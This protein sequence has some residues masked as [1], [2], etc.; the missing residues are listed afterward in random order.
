MYTDV[1]APHNYKEIS[2]VY[3]SPSPSMNKQVAEYFLLLNI[4]DVSKIVGQNLE[5]GRS[6]PVIKK[7]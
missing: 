7:I 2:S 3:P 6:R 5:T 1:H 4:Q